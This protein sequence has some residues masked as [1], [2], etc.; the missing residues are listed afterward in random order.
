MPVWAEF[1]EKE[2]ETLSNVAL[3]S[4]QLAKKRGVQVFSPGQVLEKKLGFDFAAELGRHSRLHR[5]LFGGTPGMP[6]ITAAQSASLGMPFVSSTKLLNVFLQYKRPEHF[7]PGHRSLLWPKGEEFLRFTVSE[8]NS[9]GGGWHFSQV[10][11]LN[12][13]ATQLQGTALVRY[14]CPAVWTR[15]DLYGLYSQGQLLD[16]CA[17][18]DPRKL[19]LGTPGQQFHR[20]WTFQKPRPDFGKPNPDGALTKV[21]NGE[22]FVDRAMEIARRSPLMIDYPDEL[23]RDAPKLEEVRE[24]SEARKANLA[25]RRRA[26]TQ[27]EDKFLKRDL[28]KIPSDEREVVRAS[29]EFA[30]MSRDLSAQWFVLA[31]SEP[32]V[33]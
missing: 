27:R 4:E 11:A 32:R 17:F 9:A 23:I 26:E 15:T 33:D 13:L 12:S 31:F 21:E 18:V 1:E 25:T 5:R 16:N 14:A 30:K 19:I 28:E 8:N 20:R 29:L 10:S 7:R 22:E 6:G 24:L 3:V 2:F